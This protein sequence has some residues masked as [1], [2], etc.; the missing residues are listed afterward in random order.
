MRRT[1]EEELA[2]AIRRKLEED[3]AKVHWAALLPETQNEV[4]WI[5]QRRAR[6]GNP[7][8]ITA[9]AM[10]RRISQREWARTIP[11]LPELNL[12]GG[13]DS[14]VAKIKSVAEMLAAPLRSGDGTLFLELLA[15]RR[16]KGKRDLDDPMVR[17]KI[18]QAMGY[19]GNPTQLDVLDSGDKARLE[20][21]DIIQGLCERGTNVDW[22]KELVAF[23]GSVG[24][25]NHCA[26]YGRLEW[27]IYAHEHGC[28]WDAWTCR[29]AAEGGHRDV[30]RYA[31]EHG[32]PWGAGTCEVAAEGGHLETLRYAHENGCP[33]D[34]VT[35]E[36]AAAS[37]HL[38][39]LRYAH[40]NGCPWDE[41]T[42]TFAA[43]GGHLD[44]LRYAH[45]HA[46]PWN[47]QTCISAAR[48]G[49]LETLRYAHDHGCPWNTETCAAAAK[50]GHLDVLRYAHEHAC[51]W[52]EV[53]CAA[54]AK[55]GHRDVLR[56]LHEQDCP[57]AAQTCYA[58]AKHGH[59]DVLRY[60]H[61]AGCPWNEWTCDAAAMNGH[62][63]VLRYAVT[64]G[65]PMPWTE[66]VQVSEAYLPTIR[67]YL[68]TT[69]TDTGHRR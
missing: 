24:I 39:T 55:G 28:P 61:E 1:R 66:I 9:L 30:L 33:W 44:V 47:A 40:E 36:A 51:P 69:A 32:C 43:V 18:A 45:E 19:H 64:H 60:A 37:G 3:P 27:L 49:H 7:D 48:N 12:R 56:Y 38:E 22:F 57:W 14:S 2:R 59:L 21:G 26:Q 68:A 23:H 5:M 6:A 50:H 35:C 46:C 17:E 31:H 25:A 41:V 11:P 34:E 16:A 54:A 53:T 58:A 20:P 42:C 65:C 29:R 8:W 62:L 67:D 15:W 13:A 10:L 4:L 52:D 63:D